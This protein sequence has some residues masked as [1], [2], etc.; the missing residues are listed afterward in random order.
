MRL[1]AHGR[2]QA[3]YAGWDSPLR[4]TGIA[5]YAGMGG[6]AEGEPPAKGETEDPKPACGR[7]A[8]GRGRQ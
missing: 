8:G 6:V 3:P 4:R 7:R 2:E 1:A 5:P